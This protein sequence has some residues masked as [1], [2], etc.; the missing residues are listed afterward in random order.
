MFSVQ[1]VK[2]H[3]KWL[4]RCGS[5][6]LMR[7]RHVTR[8]RVTRGFARAPI[9]EETMN[10]ETVFTV[11]ATADAVVIPPVTEENEES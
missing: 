2:H 11:T 10:P 9:K 6:L 1:R 7:G 3:S 4:L 5:T 8:V